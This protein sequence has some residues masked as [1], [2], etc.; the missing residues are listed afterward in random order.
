MTAVF[1]EVSITWEGKAWR[2]TPS[3]GLMRRIEGQGISLLHMINEMR[4]GRPH[5]SALVTVVAE[6]LM[7]AGATV[8]EDTLL[9]EFLSAD[10][11][12][13]MLLAGNVLNA[14]FPDV[15]GKKPSAPPA[16]PAR[17]AKKAS[18]PR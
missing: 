14:L 8:D 2:F 15:D 9:A 6:C 4:H 1:R 7:A 17:G 12:D 5:V 13:M 10:G 3:L 16:G 18:R 11:N